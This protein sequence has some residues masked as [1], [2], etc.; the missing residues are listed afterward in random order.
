M[1]FCPSQ[2]TNTTPTP[3][4]FGPTSE[5]A[6]FKLVNTTRTGFLNVLVEARAVF[7]L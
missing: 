3:D 4:R 7:D 6:F 1:A 5:L 2:E